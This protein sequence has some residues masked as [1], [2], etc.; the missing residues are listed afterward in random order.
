VINKSGLANFF[1]LV[2]SGTPAKIE[3]EIDNAA[4]VRTVDETDYDDAPQVLW[5]QWSI[6]MGL[7]SAS[8]SNCRRLLHD[9][10]RGSLP[11]RAPIIILL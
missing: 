4:D 6:G 5:T 8:L 1:A 9:L 11:P 10:K 7:L 2:K 3:A